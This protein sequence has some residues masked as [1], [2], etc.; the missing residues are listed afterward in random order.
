[1]KQYFDDL[2]TNELEVFSLKNFQLQKL[3]RKDNLEC[4][5]KDNI[6]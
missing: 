6:G 2:N 1:M 5:R 4:G 3:N